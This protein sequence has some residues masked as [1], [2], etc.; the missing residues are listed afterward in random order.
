MGLNGV[1]NGASQA[2]RFDVL[3]IGAGVAGINTAYRLQTQL[4]GTTFTIL[5]GRGNI[6]G[7]WDLFRY[8]GIRSDSDLFTYGFQWEPWPYETPIAQGPLIR[9]YM[10]NCVTK[11]NLGRYIRFH[12]KV[13]SADWSNATEQWKITAEHDG[14]TKEF[15]APWV[16]FAT[17]YY[18]YENPLPTVIPGLGSFKGKIIHPQ[19]WPEDY[20]YSGKRMIVIGSGATAVT[21]LPAL[22]ETAATVTMVQRSP[23]YIVSVYNGTPNGSW[24]MRN[25]PKYYAATWLRIQALWKLHLVVLFCHYFPQ[26][27]RNA[28]IKRTI[29]L[30]PKRISHSPHFEPSYTPWQQRLCI[31]PDGDFYQALREKPN[32]N[33][34][35]GHIATV[36]E[37]GLRMED[38]TTVDAD[39]IVTATGIHMRMGG[40][41][42]VTVDGKKMDWAGRLV[43]NGSMLQDV[44]N[45]MFMMGYTNA[46]WTLGADDTA[47]IFTRLTKYMESKGVSTAVPR[48]PPEGTN[49]YQRFWQLTSTYSNEAE[50]ALPRY[51]NTGPWKPKTS[52]P[53]DWL[54]GKWGDIV[55]GLQFNSS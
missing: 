30:L 13:L 36:T 7:T 35:T 16:I 55:T 34:L 37:G 22:S 50:A 47:H 46:S 18:D 2:E 42:A 4:P 54:H 33:I 39:V 15:R 17:G 20:D 28:F 29:P 24:L 51:G 21:L 25:L 5:E 49:G 32:T 12:H 31:C 53:M 6:G 19:Y 1:Q 8:P 52:P 45:M 41:I 11:Y 44:P 38:G 23:S 43:W 3:V 14:Q 48:V 40:K 10:K 9:E 26:A 27:A